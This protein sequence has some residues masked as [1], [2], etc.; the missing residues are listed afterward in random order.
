MNF[1][2]LGIESRPPAPECIVEMEDG[3]GTKMTI[4]LRGKTDLDLY[5][6]SRVFWSKPS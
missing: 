5:K 6:L 2:E 1:I 4:H 3:S